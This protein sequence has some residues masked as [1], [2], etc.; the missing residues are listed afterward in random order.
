ML[1][2]D[3]LDKNCIV[4]EDLTKIFKTKRQTI[5]ALQDIN[6]T[7]PKK[8]ITAIVGP[9]GCG[10]STIIR[11]INDIIKP[12]SGNIYV[13]GY[14]YEK[15]V[16][17]EV[18][19]KMGFIFQR[20]NILPWLTVRQNIEFPLKILRKKDEEW[21]RY[22]DELIELA[23]IKEYAEFYPSA[24]SGG[25]AQR[26]GVLRAM[27]TRPK[28]LLMD[29]PFGSLDEILREQL[30]LQTLELWSKLGQ[31]IIF[32]THNVSEAVLMS[33]KVYVM[34]TEPG[35]V[36]EEVHIDFPYPRTLDII[37]D[38]KFVQYERYITSLIGELDLSHIK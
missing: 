10:K 32:I 14:K 36:L 8:Q 35:R 20:S 31:T 23:G 21:Y 37:A 33:S 15:Y 5:T 7:F 22:V 13:D 17:D 18:I 12:T 29:E 26:V 2:N 19:R 3:C 6:M 28:I 24:L 25:V 34:A 30:D 16:P 27:A 1:E 9:S 11:L 4:L 38:D